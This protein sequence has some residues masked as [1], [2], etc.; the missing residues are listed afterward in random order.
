MNMLDPTA[1]ANPSDYSPKDI[2]GLFVRRFK[3]HRAPSQRAS[4]PNARFAGHAG[5]ATDVEEAAFDSLVNLSFK[6]IDPRGGGSMLF[7]T[8]RSKRPLL[9]SPAACVK[10]IENRIRTLENAGTDSAMHD[11]AALENLRNSVAAITPADFSKYQR[12]LSVV[13]EHAEFKWTGHLRSDRLVIFTER[14]ETLK[15]LEEN[16]VK[17]LGLDPKKVATLYGSMSDVDQQE[18][19]EQFGQESSTSGFSSHRTWPARASTFTTNAI[20]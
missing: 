17:D 19:V 7:K 9:S 5:T 8:P 20:G 18:I 10:T 6:Q 2:D 1:I 11:I 15:F 12:L 16:L 4:F 13:R 14:I 3:G